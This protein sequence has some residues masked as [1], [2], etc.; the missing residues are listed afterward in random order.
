MDDYLLHLL[1]HTFE[2]ICKYNVT[3]SKWTI[4]HDLGWYFF[5]E[6]LFNGFV[7]CLEGECRG[8]YAEHDC[9]REKVILKVFRSRASTLYPL[10]KLNLR[11]KHQVMGSRF[12]K[13]CRGCPG[14]ASSVSAQYWDCWAR[15]FDCAS[16]IKA[17][18]KLRDP[19]DDLLALMAMIDAQIVETN[20]LSW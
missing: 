14:R 19:I 20:N 11:L 18:T 10:L 4:L 16:N 9:Q 12:T 13:Q 6:F 17:I 15:E 8:V 2:S 7:L 3:F 1:L 5:N